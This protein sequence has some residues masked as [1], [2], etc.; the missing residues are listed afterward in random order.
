MKLNMNLS[1]YLLLFVSSLCY[2]QMEGYNYKMELEGIT[3]AWHK[4]TLPNSIFKDIDNSLYDIRIFGINAN[5]DTIE[6]PYLLR[7]K[8]KKIT[9][10]TV[11][12]NRL[13]E[14]YA[15][16]EYFVTFEVPTDAAVNLM[17]LDFKQQNYDWRLKLEG[18][19]DNNK[20]FEMTDDYRILS[21][22]NGISNY[23]F[24]K[25]SFP[26]SKYL[27]YRLKIKASEKP[28]LLSAKLDFQQIT[29]AVYN[30]FSLKDMQINNN[31]ST[32]Q[33]SVEV[34]L[35]TAAPVSFL[36]F[37]V[38]NTF[39]YYRPI[40]IHYLK[41]SIQTE[42]GWKYNYQTLGKGTLSSM[43]KEGFTF[44][45]TILQ[46][47]KIVIENH[48]NEPL[49]INSVQV[50]GYVH[51]LI[52]RF[53]EPANYYLTYGKSKPVKPNYDISKFENSIPKNLN[54]LKLKT[55]LSI[56]KKIEEKIE[57]LFKNKLWLWAIMGIIILVL[58][59]FSIKMIKQ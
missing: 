25:V 24:T 56:K 22:K 42:Q 33:T 23:Q 29:P 46:K 31:R 53:S 10:Q 35:N 26:N 36:V 12:F 55:P 38:Q 19:L 58:G 57:P 11:N 50:K 41:D 3:N 18:S 27:Y 5:N 30:S 14:S 45:S 28:K 39:D 9:N 40:T 43:E 15:L 51:E 47:L 52:V 20:W 21:F 7:R 32:K 1:L 2:G 44:E 17:E 59:L 16:E 48:D 13:N 54:S 8:T 49:K 37:D 4:I 34:T 6:T